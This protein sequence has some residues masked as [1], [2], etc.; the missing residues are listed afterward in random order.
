MLEE[1][2]SFRPL[3]EFSCI[4]IRELK[5]FLG[6]NKEVLYPAVSGFEIVEFLDIRSEIAAKGWS[7]P[8]RKRKILEG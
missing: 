4:K 2:I 5:E 8:Q 1:G 6:H 7:F 3:K